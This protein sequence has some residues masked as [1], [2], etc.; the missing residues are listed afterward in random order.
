MTHKLSCNIDAWR[1]IISDPWILDTVMG[2]E[3]EF[4]S[5]PVTHWCP[6]PLKLAPTE[7]YALDENL[8]EFLTMGVICR[9]SDALCQMF[10]LWPSMTI[11]IEPSSMSK[12]SI[13]WWLT[14]ISRWIQFVRSYC[15]SHRNVSWHPL[16]LFK[17]AYFS[18]SI[19]AHDRQFQCFDWKGDRFPF[20]CLPQGLSSAP[21]VFT[22][23]M[24]PALSVLRSRGYTIVSHIDDSII[25]VETRE[26]LLE[27]VHEAMVLF[28][29]LGL[30]V[31]PTK[32]DL[33]ARQSIAFLGFIINSVNMTLALTAE[34]QDKITTL[35][36]SLR[37][38]ESFS[39]CDLA[40]F[41]GNVTLR[42]W[43]QK[44]IQCWPRLV[45]T[46]T[47]LC[48]IPQWFKSNYDGLLIV[49]PSPLRHGC[50]W[51]HP[52]P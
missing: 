33:T 34:K 8:S 51:H 17:H 25:I 38:K 30:T 47:A 42:L 28:D 6:R 40:S 2:Y 7:Q 9:C 41:I 11:H 36:R 24:K 52:L 44:G 1:A 46:L 29:S 10:S 15:L 3:I 5:L 18:V 43:K 32:S 48:P 50:L 39:I 37:T 49:F 22:K 13:K 20:T 16:T 12:N 19:H 31:H 26:E 4:D 23:L 35:A 21:R 14:T 45:V 27:A